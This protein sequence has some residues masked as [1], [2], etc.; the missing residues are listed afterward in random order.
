MAV[1]P[2]KSNGKKPL[3]R[4]VSNGFKQAT[5]DEKKIRDYW[6][7]IPYANIGVAT[8]QVFVADLDVKNGVNGLDKPLPKTKAVHT[9]NGGVHLYFQAPDGIEVKS[10]TSAVFGEGIDVRGH[11]GYVV[12]PP[13]SLKNGVYRFRD[14]TRRIA[15]ASHWLISKVKRD[16]RETKSEGEPND[17]P[18]AI[19][20]GTRNYTL[21]RIGCSLRERPGMTDEELRT[22]LHKLTRC[23]AN[24]LYRLR[25][26]IRS[27]IR[28]PS[29]T[30][31]ECVFRGTQAMGSSAGC[32]NLPQRTPIKQS[33]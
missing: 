29:G 20:G 19:H 10:S 8:G 30:N 4:L 26:S 16:T 18:T 33:K 22:S 6:G 1:F 7:V 17:M 23:D 3:G 27:S 14:D 5:T 2:V 21:F 31:R 11:G 28:L 24:R 25:K 9:P 32:P 13:S 12:A 15:I